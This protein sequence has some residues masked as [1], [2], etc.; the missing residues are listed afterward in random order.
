MSKNS[1]AILILAHHNPQQLTMLINHLSPDFDIYVQI[2]KKANFDRN[3]LPT[4]Q[5]IFCYK[6]IEVY[7]GHISQIYNMK[8]IFEQAFKKGYDRYCMISGDDLPIKSNIYIQDFFDQNKN[9]I[10]M[11]ANPLPIK[12]WGFNN[13]FD[14]LD[15]YWLMHNKNRK[16]VKITGRLTLFIQRLIGV[17]KKRYP[18]D[19]YAGS[20]WLNLTHESLDVVFNFLK[21]NPSFLEKLKYSRATDEIWIQSIIMNSHLKE[22][23]INNDLRYIDW[24]TGPNYPKILDNTDLPKIKKSNSLFARKFDSKNTN[25]ELRG[26]LNTLN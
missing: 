15:R 12:T 1:V 14:R 19:Y 2:D 18:L 16:F 17:K 23:V 22:L 11:Y 7:W 24:E 26:F 6:N 20:N 13:G 10:F 4:A 21:K 5:N 9:K 8:Y 25:I 3:H